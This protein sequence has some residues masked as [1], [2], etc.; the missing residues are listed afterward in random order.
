MAKKQEKKEEVLTQESKLK[1]T[2]TD[3]ED[4]PVANTDIEPEE[5]ENEEVA[6][7]SSISEASEAEKKEPEKEEKPE[8]ET[9]PSKKEDTTQDE[10][11]SQPEEKKPLLNKK[12]FFIFFLV[13]A[14]GAVTIGGIV[15]SRKSLEKQT[16]IPEVATIV[17]SIITP[18]QSQEA[19]QSATTSASPSEEQVNLSDYSAQVLNGSGKVG[20]AGKAGDILEAEGFEGIKLGNADSYDFTDTQVSL[21]Q[22]TPKFVFDA[23]E[24]A[25]K[26]D[27]AVKKVDA[28]DEDSEFDVVIIVGSKESQAQEAEE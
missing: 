17:E 2:S 9:V 3:T 1:E 22:G 8:I 4:K 7:E 13:L 23:I 25:L 14:I 12:L 24:S 18:T 10:Q 19:T 21:K 5:T 27:Y 15:V 6:Q 26:S 16:E 11:I 20:E 28:L